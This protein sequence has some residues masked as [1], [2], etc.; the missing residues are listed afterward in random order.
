M[1]VPVRDKCPT[2]DPNHVDLSDPAFRA[3]DNPDL[4]HIPV[5]WKFVH[6]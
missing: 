6:S 4:G 2:C 1:A 3:L 5:T